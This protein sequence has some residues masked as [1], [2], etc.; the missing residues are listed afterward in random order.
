MAPYKISY[1][2]PNQNVRK[3]RP[4]VQQG[5]VPQDFLVNQIVQS[6]TSRPYIFSR[7]LT[8][9]TSLGPRPFSTGAR[10]SRPKQTGVFLY[11]LFAFRQDNRFFV[12]SRFLIVCSVVLRRG[13]PVALSDWSMAAVW[14]FHSIRCTRRPLLL[15][16]TET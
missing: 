13:C 8:K 1:K 5:S 16:N 15:Q 12:T 11:R 6:L 3:F 10:F 9:A 14:C 4:V 2:I 7:D